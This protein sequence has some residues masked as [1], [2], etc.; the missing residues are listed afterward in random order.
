MDTLLKMAA[1]DQ[2]SDSDMVR[3]QRAAM[4]DPSAPNPSVEAILHAVIPYVF[5]D[6]THTDALVTLTNTADGEARIRAVYGERVLIIP[7]VMPGF[8][9]A[10]LIY[11]RTRNVDW[12]AL[13]G[14]VLMNHGLFT[15]ADDARSAY[16]KHIELVTE[17]EQYLQQQGAVLNLTDVSAAPDLLA[18]ARIR[19]AVSRCKGQAVIA[20]LNE[21][22]LAQR[23]SE[24]DL[25]ALGSWG[26]LTPE[27]VIRTKRSPL[28]LP[29]EATDAELESAVEQ[30]AAG[31][32]EYFAAHQAAGQI[33]LN[34][35]PNYA[36]WSG[37]GAISFGKSL[38]EAR[39]IR[40][41]NDHTFEAIMKAELL[42]GYQALDEATLFEI[43]YWELEQAKL[44][45]GTSVAGLSGKIA[46]LSGADSA[47]GVAVGQQLQR[48]GATVV[49]LQSSADID[50][51]VLTYGGIDL[52]VLQGGAG[53]L[54]LLRAALPYL[55]C[56]IEPTVL[57]IGDHLLGLTAELTREDLKVIRLCSI[58][59]QICPEGIAA[60]AGVLSSDLFSGQPR[61]N[62]TI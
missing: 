48:L 1:L 12:A 49:A 9:L 40:D 62:V 46:L 31:Y 54:E 22:A 32:R 43:E 13:D 47:A 58:A 61:V 3:Y 23:F 11:Q 57:S 51:A 33:C 8:E 20:H 21:G 56:G 30:Y 44:R 10:R 37:R 18:L 53:E 26:T 7:Y 4:I 45:S 50:T 34:P 55:H 25:V 36:V 59:A 28:L 14:I 16:N 15:F 41:I 24:Q 35:A 52:L 17:A 38:G 60:L 6:H 5:V 42:G 2:L 27:H 39:V 29:P 19:R